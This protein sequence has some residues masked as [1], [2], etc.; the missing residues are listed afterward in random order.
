VGFEEHRSAFERRNYSQRKKGPKKPEKP[1][2]AAKCGFF[3]QPN[4]S[5]PK[6]SKS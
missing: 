4:Q 1:N 3:G 5:T 2:L 6:K